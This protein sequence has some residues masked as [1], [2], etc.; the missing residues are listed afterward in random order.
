M[1]S[2]NKDRLTDLEEMRLKNESLKIKYNLIKFLIGTVMLSGL[3]LLVNWGIQTQ[4]LKNETQ[5]K[6]NE[7]IGQFVDHA[8]NEKLEYRLDFA[9]YLFQLSTSKSSKSRWNNYRNYIQNKMII[10]DSIELKKK[11]LEKEKYLVMD[12][13]AKMNL[14]KK[15]KSDLKKREIK[16]QARLKS[17]HAD[18]K[19]MEEEIARLTHK[20]DLKKQQFVQMNLPKTV[21]P[22]V[23]EQPVIKTGNTAQKQKDNDLWEWKVFIT[24]HKSILEN[25]KCVE[26]TLH[27][28]FP[29]PVN[30]VC[31]KGSDSQAFPFEAQGWGTF[32]IKVIVY[33]KDK[34]F[35]ELYHDLNF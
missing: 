27:P 34:S 28:T 25:I 9:E 21:V 15:K 26:Y 33:F 30:L 14:S 18:D 4:Q 3:T 23:P 29:N 31:V 22:T 12:T 13:V 17:L 10:R 5:I 1:P 8:L 19:K 11:E 20:P 32:R 2:E 16:L 35:S 24:A 7:F 6:E